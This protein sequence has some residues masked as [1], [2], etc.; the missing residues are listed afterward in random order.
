[1]SALPILYVEDEENDGFLLRRAFVKAGIPNP[2]EV[3]TDGNEAIEYL[4]GLGTYTKR[5]IPQLVFLDL[6]LPFKTGF[7]VLAWL[8]QQPALHTI[9]VIILTSSTQESDVHKAYALGANAYLVKPPGPE[10]LTVMVETIRAFWL[11]LNLNPPDALA[12]QDSHD[13]APPKSHL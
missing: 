11:T 7:E 13:K 12:F 3:V 8:R 10:E 6:K 4:S 1:L 2:L 9:P 5:R